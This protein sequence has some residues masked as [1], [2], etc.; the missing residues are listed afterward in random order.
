MAGRKAPQGLAVGGRKLWSA[1]CA[2]HEDLD[3]TQL[4]QLEEACRAKDRLDELDSIIHGKGVLDLMRF[5][6]HES[7][8]E[9]GDRTV[10]VEVKFDNVITTA[11]ATANLMKQLLAALRLPDAVTG[12]KPQYRGPRGAQKPSIPGGAAEDSAGARAKQRW[13]A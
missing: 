6:L 3:A 4:V 1:I 8:G 13:G 11:N 5:R 7:W 2:D 12:K 9:D 10:L